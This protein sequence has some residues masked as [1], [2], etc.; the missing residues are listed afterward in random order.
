MSSA[1]LSPRS[2]PGS[3]PRAASSRSLA[4]ATGY[5]ELDE[6][7]ISPSD[8]AGWLLKKGTATQSDGLIQRALKVRGVNI[9]KWSNERDPYTRPLVFPPNWRDSTHASCYGP[10]VLLDFE[11]LR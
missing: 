7:L 8:E 1:T 4:W 5:S 10:A 2:P 11:K 6:D 9:I 3:T